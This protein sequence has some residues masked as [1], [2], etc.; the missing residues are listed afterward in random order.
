MKTILKKVFSIR[1]FEFQQQNI[2][3]ATEN[4]FIACDMCLQ[5]KGNPFQNIH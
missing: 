1:C 2:W 3:C 4:M 5:D